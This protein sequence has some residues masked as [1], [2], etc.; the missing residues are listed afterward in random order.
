[1]DNETGEDS[2]NDRVSF[3]SR[4]HL[5]PSSWN[6]LFLRRKRCNDE[7]QLNTVDTSGLE[8]K[9]SYLLLLSQV[10][11]MFKIQIRGIGAYGCSPTEKGH[12]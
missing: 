9:I 8:G 7:E 3:F 5:F 6:R 11:T 1:M 12:R 2:A 10:I 4:P